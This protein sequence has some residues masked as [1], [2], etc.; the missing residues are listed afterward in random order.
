M[1]TYHVY[2]ETSQDALDEGGPLAHLPELPGCTAR[3]KTVEATKDAIR[4]AAQ[5]YVAFLRTQGERSLPDEFDFDF[6]EVKDYTLPPDYEPTTPEEIARAKRWLE[7]SRRV[8][9]AEIGYLP[10]EAWDWKPAPDE[11]SLRSITNHM[12]GAELYLTD[13]LM[14]PDRA[15]PDRLETTRRAAFERL[16]ALTAENMS[17]VTTF[18]GEA[19]TPKKV[20]RRMLE[21]EQEHL[22]QIRD[23]VARFK[24]SQ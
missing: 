14:E 23:L 7:A 2:I 16:D 12:G 18:D 10:S 11:W 15:L 3:G 4:R 8:V 19:W 24:S 9:L 17:R 1:K 20:L 5:D 6:H 21:H 22:A 13:K